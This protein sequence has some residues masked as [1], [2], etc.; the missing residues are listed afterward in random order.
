MFYWLHFNHRF[1]SQT[2]T[3]FNI[4][5]VYRYMWPHRD[6][7]TISLLGL[8]MLCLGELSYNP[9]PA[10]ILF[11]FLNFSIILGMII[12]KYTSLWNRVTLE[13]N[14]ALLGTA[15]TSREK[16]TKLKAMGSAHKRKPPCKFSNV[17][18][19]SPCPPSVATALLTASIS[20]LKNFNI[21][22]PSLKWRNTYMRKKRL[23]LGCVI[24]MS[25]L[26]FLSQLLWYKILTSGVWSHGWMSLWTCGSWGGQN[27]CGMF[28]SIPCWCGSLSLQVW[29]CH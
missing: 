5:F 1:T 7:G 19:T 8:I 6:T 25:W 21:R 11:L 13:M 9:R 17:N 15:I 16:M 20:S 27:R 23:V 10:L 12:W 3:C 4:L 18:G 2:C 28:S 26:P 22:P 24:P 14:C 29:K